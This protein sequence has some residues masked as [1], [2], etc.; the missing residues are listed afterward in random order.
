MKFSNLF[1]AAAAAGLLLALFY[2]INIE[3]LLTALSC[4]DLFDLSIAFAIGFIGFIMTSALRWQ[5]ILLKLYRIAIPYRLAL[6]YYWEGLFVGYFV[7]GGIG[8]DI[9]RALASGRKTRA[10]HRNIV[11]VAG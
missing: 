1:K 4:V 10:F 5:M 8:A 3:K 7:P 9:Y 6:R 11:C 2:S